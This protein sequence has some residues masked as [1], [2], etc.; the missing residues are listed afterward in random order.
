[1]LC[2]RLSDSCST[3]RAYGAFAA[4]IADLYVVII[5]RTLHLQQPLHAA[6]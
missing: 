3:G 5:Q 1:M 6:R 2:Y 4:R